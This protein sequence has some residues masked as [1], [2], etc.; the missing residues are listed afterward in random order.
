MKNNKGVGV[1]DY[2]KIV[3]AECNEPYSNG[4]IL[5]VID[6]DGKSGNIWCENENNQYYIYYDEYEF[7]ST[8][9]F[10]KGNLQTGDFVEYRNRCAGI[11]NIEAG[12]IARNDGD[13]NGLNALT[14]HLEHT[15][16]NDEWIIDKV[17]RPTEPIAVSFI[18]YHKGRLIFDR[19]A[20]QAPKEY[21]I[22]E[23]ESKLGEKIKIIGNAA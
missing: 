1:G 9:N 22:E 20:I 11:V 12:G 19:S 2:V 17:Y 21:T 5:K 3:D 6:L 10:T 13:Y 4:D 7:F 16:E 14:D 8:D 18:N 15:G 23:L